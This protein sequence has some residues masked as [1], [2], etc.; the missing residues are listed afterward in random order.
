[1]KR[2]PISNDLSWWAVNEATWEMLD[3]GFVSTAGNPR[4]L[5]YLKTAILGGC[6][7][8]P[9]WEPYSHVLTQVVGRTCGVVDA[10]DHCELVVLDVKLKPIDHRNHPRYVRTNE[11]M[12]VWEVGQLLGGN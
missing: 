5:A 2:Q 6:A 10:E 4:Q 7:E 8:I 9:N 3:A 12:P 1:M 11:T